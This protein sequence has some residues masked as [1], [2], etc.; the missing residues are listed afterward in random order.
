MTKTGENFSIIG[1]NNNFLSRTI[2]RHWPSK[3]KTDKLATK[4]I[5]LIFEK[6]M[7]NEKACHRL[8]E[9]SFLRPI[10]EYFVEE[11]IWTNSSW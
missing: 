6:F 11:N 10:I 7:Q 2:K 1:L 3:K 8:R 9:K 5:T 4:L